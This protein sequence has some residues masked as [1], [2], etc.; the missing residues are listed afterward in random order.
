MTYK[1]WKNGD[2]YL[3]ENETG[4]IELTKEDLRGLGK[5]A[6]A[7]RKVNVT[8]GDGRKRVWT[9]ER[10][11]MQRERIAAQRANGRDPRLGTGA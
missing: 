6:R 9:P 2:E 3:I 8:A 4:R 1:I 10:R 11:Q 7:T 5:A